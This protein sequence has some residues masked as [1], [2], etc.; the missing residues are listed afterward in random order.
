MSLFVDPEDPRT[1]GPTLSDQVSGMQACMAVL[2]A[3]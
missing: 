1:L 2:G 3:L